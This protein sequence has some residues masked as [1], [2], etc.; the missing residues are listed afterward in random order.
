MMNNS[1]RSAW[2]HLLAHRTF[3]L[4]NIIGLA[5]GIAACILIGLSVSHERSFDADIP[6]IAHLYRL[7]EYVHY[8]GTPPQVAGNVGAPIAP[9]LAA[10]H[11][12]IEA[13][14][15]VIPSSWIYPSTTLEK[16]G[17]SIKTDELVCTDTAFARL[18]GL[19]F[20][21]GDKADYA[22]TINTIVLTRS[23]AHRLF[24]S[25]SALHK[26]L[27]LKVDDTI[28]YPVAVT[29]VVEDLPATSHLQ[30]EAM[31]PVPKSFDTGWAGKNW[32]MFVAA[33]YAR[34]KP[35][36][37]PEDLQ[38]QLTSA[39]HQKNTGIDIRLQPVSDLH[40]GSIDVNFDHFNFQKIDGKYLRV[41]IIIG[42]AIFIIACC[43]FVNLTIA[44]AAYRGKEVAMKKIMG[45]RRSH[46]L[47]QVLTE[48]FL[49][50]AI[51]IGLSVG[52]VALFLPT[53]NNLLGRE[54]S[55]TSLW[56]WPIIGIYGAILLATTLFA[57]LYP[58]ILIASARAQ[59]ALRSKVLLGGSRTSLRN[60]LVT[61]Q[62]AI[63][64]IFI[65][66]LIVFVRQLNYMQNKDLGYSHEQIYKVRLEGKDQAKAY[67]FRNELARVPG[68][69]S[70]AGG[71]FEL[72]TS[73]GIFGVDYLSADGQQKHESF[74]FENGTPNYV[75][76]F[77]MKI[78]AGR[79]FT[80]GKP[81]NEYL[82]NETLAKHLGYA[83]P[84][85]KPIHVSSFDA[86]TIVG[87]VKD[88]NFSSL[89]KKIEPL[90][91]G[92]ID[93]V[94][95]WQRELYL[96][97]ATADL[98]QTLKA[99]NST[100][101]SLSADDKR[102]TGQFLDDQFRQ[103][104]A[105]DKQAGSMIAVIGTLAVII[106]GLGLFGLAAFI[107]AKRTKEISIRK[108]LGASV[109][110]VVGHLSKSFLGLVVIA[111]CVATPITWVLTNRW[112]EGFAY[113]IEVQWWMF[114]L[115]GVLAVGIALL[116]VGLLA[117]RAAV[118]NPVSSLRTE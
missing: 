47:F 81:H 41:F 104:Y 48:A 50:T 14:A 49:S 11:P 9:F 60:I 22:R 69:K 77:G 45:A 25:E 54:L 87:V 101:Q 36:T 110:N 32:G 43:N 35:G 93:Y 58:A 113:R 116:I 2:R 75:K 82:I 31:M 102:L 83:D 70:V 40:T 115:A 59:Q 44:L 105:A 37:N 108:V 15:R 38:A 73:G 7:N 91:I 4:I 62:F 20:L 29:G 1:F 107:M 27:L 21:E 64:V 6:N 80:P 99:I 118:A 30:A 46:L 67:L 28:R 92:S 112:L 34:V 12:G 100:L 18:F 17:N 79:D 56:H 57:G 98:P 68:V 24:G 63:A 42:L 88:F 114:V 23:L 96:K 3:T 94:P 117:L 90:L 76:F 109:T 39:I 74:N 111:F 66:C 78:V 97:V 51:A 89:H 53:L 16:G 84:I 55:F 33:A 19:R 26:T 85:G 103:L 10:D 86:G 95:L 52:L 61:G 106:A 72:G 65:V 8:D 13:F 5:I 71:F